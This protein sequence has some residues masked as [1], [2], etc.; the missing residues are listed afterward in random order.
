[1]ADTANLM[2]R[3]G[4]EA[5]F[6]TKPGVCRSIPVIDAGRDVPGS[7]LEYQKEYAGE[8]IGWASL[9]F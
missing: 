4:R 1:M 6:S 9:T 3:I 8:E 2:T 5:R 7:E